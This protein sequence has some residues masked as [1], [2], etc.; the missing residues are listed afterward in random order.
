MQTESSSDLIEEDWP[1]WDDEEMHMEQLDRQEL[2]PIRTYIPDAIHHEISQ[3]GSVSQALMSED[4]MMCLL[5]QAVERIQQFGSE[6]AEDNCTDEQLMS[7]L[8]TVLLNPQ[9][10]V[11]DNLTTH[12]IAWQAF[13]LQFGN[14]MKLQL[15]KGLLAHIRT[16]VMILP[17]VIIIA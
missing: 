9:K 6:Q 10:F 1:K 17:C 4:T 3:P 5:S 13:F 2:L 15:P 8:H 14:T 11:A 16:G 12:V 7:Y